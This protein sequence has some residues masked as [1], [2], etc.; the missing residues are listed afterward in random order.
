M[1]YFVSILATAVLFVLLILLLAVKPKISRM[2]T[3]GALAFAGLSGL[4]IYGYGYMAV[5]GNFFLA[6]LKALLAVCGSFIGKNEYSAISSVP[7]MQSIWMQILCTF[8]QICALY[9]TASAVITSIGTEALKR[10]RL[11]L[12]RRGELDLIYGIHADAL[13]FGKELAGRKRGAV[14]FV[15]EQADPAAAAEI[16][17]MGCVLRT[18]GHALNADSRFLRGIGFR[19]RR[20]DLTLYALDKDPT[21][22]LR[23][24]NALLDTLKA[25]NTSPEQLRLVILGQEEAAVSRLQ[26]TADRY[27]Y[28]FVTAVNEP[29]MAARLLTLKYPP[30]ETISFG[31]DGKAREDF[32]ALLIG[33]GQVGQ[34]VLRAIVMNGQFEGSAFRMAVF[35]PDRESADGSFATQF[36]SL[37]EEYDITFYDC[38][39]RSRKMY[40]YL[41]GHGEKL[42][43]VAICT[44]S[45]ALNHEIAE[46]LTAYFRGLGRSVPVFSCSRRGVDAYAPDGAVAASH[47]LYHGDLLNNLDW[48]AMILNHRYHA[49][50]DKTALQNW[51]DCDYFSRQ[52]CRAAADFVPA[53]LRA[54]EKAPDQAAGGDWSLTEAQKENLSKTEHLRWCAFHYCMGFSPM[55]AQEFDTRAAAYRRQIEQDG[56]AS[57]RI[58]KNMPGRT[59]ACLVPWDELDRL[60]EKE[61]AVTGK[62]VDYK[63]MDTENVLSIPQLLQSAEE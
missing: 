14:V 46:E 59:H 37:C 49:Q 47:K 2:I 57:I 1:I 29:Q 22:N 6:V 27:G 24:A 25:D 15:A 9:A 17:S 53:M 16:S 13:E 23:Y 48:T 38:D 55:S 41:S 62:Y 51:M 7:V 42:N 3:V 52:S 60:S 63:A 35:A 26:A 40:E 12:A 39:A 43:Y 18:D 58:G 56:K 36:R 4:L 33:F 32:E 28:G 31:P 44:G 30:C 10:L 19:H 5:T 8:I 61:A 11:W 54:A 50:S 20:R 34:A 45:D 21:A